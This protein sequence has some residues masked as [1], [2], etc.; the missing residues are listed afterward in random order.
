MSMSPMTHYHYHIHSRTPGTWQ[1]TFKL[2]AWVISPPGGSHL[3]DGHILKHYQLL[4]LAHIPLK[5]YLKVSDMVPS[6]QINLCVL[7]MK[8]GRDR[9]RSDS[10]PNQ[11][12]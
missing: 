6:L 2:G 4:F 3:V 8:V 5:L 9:C 11:M 7:C 12:Y 10:V 1:G